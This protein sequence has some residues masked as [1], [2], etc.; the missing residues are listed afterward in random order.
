MPEVPEEYPAQ[1]VEGEG[2][3]ISYYGA[4]LL[5]EDR[6]TVRLYFR[7][8]DDAANH[9]FTDGTKTYTPIYKNGLY[10]IEIDGI[11]PAD[12]DV[13]YRITVDGTLTVTYGPIDYILRVYNRDSSAQELKDAVRAMYAYLCAAEDYI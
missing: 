10:Y 3:N 9:T 8:N 1:S 7:V 6:T 13:R 12:L 4:S 2:T 11:S 5:F